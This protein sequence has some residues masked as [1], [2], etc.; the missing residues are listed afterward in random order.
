MADS[1][2]DLIDTVRSLLNR[3][4]DTLFLSHPKR[5]SLGVITGLVFN[6]VSLIFRPFFE[7]LSWLDLS[8]LAA[9]H[10][11]PL[12]IVLLHI[13]T[14]YHS[15]RRYAELPEDIERA[16]FMI[17]QAEKDKIVTKREAKEL[18]QLLCTSVVDQAK[19]IPPASL[20]TD[21]K[22]TGA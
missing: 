4:I 3:A 6:T 10:Y 8:A 17:R 21:S 20:P 1:K 2:T 19:P 22:V 13:P 15:W 18:R 11:L 7:Q 9:W 16:L 5:T 12:G 14:I